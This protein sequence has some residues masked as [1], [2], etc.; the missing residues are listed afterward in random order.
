MRPF[1]ADRPR[2]EWAS[3]NSRTTFATRTRRDADSVLR[4]AALR[5]APDGGLAGAPP[6]GGCALPAP[7]PPA[8][9]HGRAPFAAGRRRH[10]RRW[11][12]DRVFVPDDIA[13]ERDPAL[14]RLLEEVAPMDGG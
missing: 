8:A 14:P 7:A 9:P 11:S 13:A 3:E 5:S 4:G 2:I 12:H 1:P 10:G 6:T